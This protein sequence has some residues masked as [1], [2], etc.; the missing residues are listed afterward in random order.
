MDTSD[1]SRDKITPKPA[2]QSSID[3]LIW[4]TIAIQI[5]VAVYGY[6]VLP[7]TVP[8][9]WGAN[10]QPNGYGPKWIGTFLYPLMSIGIYVLIR[11][12]IAAGPRLGGRENTKANLNIAKLILAGVTL[13]M[14]IIQVSTIALSLGVGFDITVIVMLAL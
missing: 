2:F 10:G 12:L 4:V 13:F 9:H 7:D 8:I 14:L 11:V 1:N 6:L 5:L 3:I